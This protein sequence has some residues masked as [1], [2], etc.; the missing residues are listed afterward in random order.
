VRYCQ[1]QQT[2]KTESHNNNQYNEITYEYDFKILCYDFYTMRVLVG[3]LGIF[4]ISLSLLVASDYAIKNIK[5]LPIESYPAR[6]SLNSVTI[7]ADPYENNEKSFTA[8]D[9]KNL[10]S[11]GYYPV[12]VIIQNSSTDYLKI[13]TRNI[14]LVTSNGQQL[15]TTPATILVE[16]LTGTGL[17]KDLPKDHFK[18]AGSPL[19]DFTEKELTNLTV[20]P[21]SVV[22]GFLFFFTQNPDKNFFNGGILYIPKLEYEGKKD[23]LGPFSISLDPALAPSNK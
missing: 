3:I 19:I 18:K 8:F 7:A 16:D 11:R 12:H 13:R 17:S 23:P 20:D 10:N 5:I 14:L 22:S 21:G 6:V 1:A 4:F 15:Y 9:I 2:V